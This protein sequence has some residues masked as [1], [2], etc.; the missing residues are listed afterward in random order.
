M[1]IAI[2]FIGQIR[3]GVIC[4]PSIRHYIG[5]LW[6]NCDIFIHTWDLE[7]KSPWV[8]GG[9][10]NSANITYYKPDDAKFSNIYNLYKPVVMVID[11]FNQTNIVYDQTHAQFYSMLRCNKSKNEYAHANNI[12]YDY[13]VKLRLDTLL[14]KSKSLKDDLALVSHS[15]LIYGDH[16]GRNF[17]FNYALEELMFM[18]TDRVM[19]FI[20]DFLKVRS[21]SILGGIDWQV[22]MKNWLMHSLGVNTRRMK[23]NYIGIYHDSNYIAAGDPAHT[24]CWGSGMLLESDVENHWLQDNVN[25]FKK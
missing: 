15:V 12:Q 5:D 2:C 11:K 24:Y 13:V 19:S 25:S 9:D 23:N 22:H 18:S 10:P 17:E 1:K 3:T 4:F 7:S 21:S 6:D 8:P 16:H 20:M 14:H